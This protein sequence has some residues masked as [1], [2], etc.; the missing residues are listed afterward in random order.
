MTKGPKLILQIKRKAMQAFTSRLMIFCL[1][2]AG[3]QSL[4]NEKNPDPRAEHIRANYTKF[5]YKIAMRNGVKLFTSVYV[6]NDNSKSYPMM[7]Q[8]TPYRVAPYGASKYKTK[9][10]PSESFEK[11]GFIFV[12]QNVRGKFMSEGEFVNMRSQ[13]PYKC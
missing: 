5:E 7:F 3:F 6:A 1:L 9:L 13:D 2:F 4:A 10:G 8:C 11:D 12:F